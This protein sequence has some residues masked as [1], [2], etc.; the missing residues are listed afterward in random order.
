M[1]LVYLLIFNVDGRLVVGDQYFLVEIHDARFHPL[2]S[3]FVCVQKHLRFFVEIKNT[4]YTCTSAVL[5]YNVLH[6]ILS[7]Y[8]FV[9]TK[10]YDAYNVFFHL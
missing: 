9:R 10:T 6:I 4:L 3:V 2:L 5:V 8:V 7:I 1:L